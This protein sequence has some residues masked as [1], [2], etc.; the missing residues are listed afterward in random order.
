MHLNVESTLNHFYR[1]N[2][3]SV[4]KIFLSN[5]IFGKVHA[6]DYLH[7]RRAAQEYMEFF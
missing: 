4:R 2:Q 6:V 7:V 5:P 3:L 1:K